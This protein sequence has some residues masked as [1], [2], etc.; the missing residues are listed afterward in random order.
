M[1]VLK[2]LKI[3]LLSLG[4]IFLYL[5]ALIAKMLEILLRKIH[6]VLGITLLTLV[7]IGVYEIILNWGSVFNYIQ[8]TLLSTNS[9]LALLTL[10]VICILAIKVSI[11]L[12]IYKR[13][14]KEYKKLINICKKD[15]ELI[16]LSNHKLVITLSCGF[17]YAAIGF[18]KLIKFIAQKGIIISIF[19]SIAA[20]ICFCILLNN[21]VYIKFGINLLHISQKIDTVSL[22]FN[23]IIGLLVM[24]NIIALII[25]LGVGLQSWVKKPK[26]ISQPQN[27]SQKSKN[28]D[29]NSNSNQIIQ[30]INI[31]IN[32][33]NKPNQPERLENAK[34]YKEMLKN[35]IQVKK[36]FES[37]IEKLLR[38]QNDN[39]LEVY[40]NEYEQELQ[41]VIN[42]F[43][44]L[45][46]NGQMP[47]SI[48]ERLIPKIK[49]LDNQ[50]K[51]L[52]KLIKELENKY[53][54]P[55]S[56][57]IFFSDCK[58]LDE[59]EKKHKAL[60]KK[61]HPDM[62][63]GDNKTFLKMQQEYEKYKSYYSV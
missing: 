14:Y 41:R 13:C 50:R 45:C 36:Q 37:K 58:T 8:S 27:I 18:E 24:T 16:Q 35:N 49:Y 22:V 63:S 62:K 39:V 48:F 3:N 7:T 32:L 19:C 34:K 17:Y 4:A 56:Q 40:W 23:L 25:L 60:C 1:A 9:V 12:E 5:I 51:E 26:N 44:T 10:F 46:E 2:I 33:H 59:F 57:S 42:T 43:N 47:I 55:L 11:F 53:N 30:I 52:E 29:I 61:Y 31:T 28:P 38:S 6:I 20:F 54:N 21:Y 15:R